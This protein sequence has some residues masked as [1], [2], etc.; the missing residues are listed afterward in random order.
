MPVWC[1]TE[2]EVWDAYSTSIYKPQAII[3]DR[4]MNIILKDDG[5]SSFERGEEAVL[6]ALYGHKPVLSAP[7]GSRM[8]SPAVRRQSEAYSG[9]S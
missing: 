7:K 6:G 4:D 9:E 2:L 3:M 1:D 5:P 8:T